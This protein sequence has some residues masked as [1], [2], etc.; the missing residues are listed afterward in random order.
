MARTAKNCNKKS[1]L[2]PDIVVYGP[3]PFFSST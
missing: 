3:L 1:A 2:R